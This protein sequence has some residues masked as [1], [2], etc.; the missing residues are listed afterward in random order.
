[1]VRALLFIAA[2]GCTD[3]SVAPIPGPSASNW[4]DEASADMRDELGPEGDNADTGWDVDTGFSEEDEPSVIDPEDESEDE[5]EVDVED[6]AGVE[7]G[8]SGDETD[9]SDGG[10]YWEDDGS[11]TWSDDDGDYGGADGPTSV[12]FPSVGEMV[13]TELMIHPEATDDAVGEWVEIRNVSGDWLSLAGHRL[14]DRGVDDVEISPV[15][16]G[17]LIVGPGEFLSI[18]AEDDYWD[19]GGVYCDGTFDYTTFGGGFALSNT[20]DEVQVL[21]STGMLIDEVRY[22][23]GFSIEGEALGLKPELASAFDNDRSDNWCGQTTFLPF[24]DAGTPG[25]QNDHCW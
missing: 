4:F 13:V 15:S 3:Y 8:G 17:S 11:D 9:D 22:G 19:N 1:M 2:V 23:E 5:S 7:E 21:S 18:C 10:D 6:G 20:E 16:A 12:R 14:G 25:G 24:G